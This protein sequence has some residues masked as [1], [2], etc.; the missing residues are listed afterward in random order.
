MKFRHTILLLALFLFSCDSQDE[1]PAPDPRDKSITLLLERFSSMEDEM[2]QLNDELVKKNAHKDGEIAELRAKLIRLE[3]KAPP[4]V[5]LPERTTPLPPEEKIDASKERSQARGEQLGTVYT[6]DGRTLYDVEII[7]VTDIGIE[8]RHNTGAARLHYNDL[9]SHYGDRFCYVPSLARKALQ[10]ER[11]ASIERN[12][13]LKNSLIEQMRR[14]GERREQALADRISQLENQQ[15][16]L[17]IEEEWLPQNH[18]TIIEETVIVGNTQQ[19]YC[20]PPVVIS[21][22]KVW[23]TVVQP[24]V[25]N[26]PTTP[27]I[28]PPMVRPRPTQTRLVA[29]TVRPSR[30]TTPRVTT[31]SVPTRPTP[32]ATRPISRPSRPAS[33][34]PALVRPSNRR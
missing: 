20:P 4:Q 27:T 6:L 3:P 21:P 23:P 9:P 18:T 2:T 30:P 31:R 16:Q 33:Q 7:R 13:H 25:V 15:R 29:P 10:L 34:S 8:I 14:E 11:L 17:V 24:P 28:R 22:P 32:T 12:Q 5:K 19:P 26:C 1:A